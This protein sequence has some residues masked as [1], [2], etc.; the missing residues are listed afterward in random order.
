MAQLTL[1]GILLHRMVLMGV[2]FGDTYLNVGKVSFLT[3]PL[4]LAMD[5]LFLFGTISDVGER[6]LKD[7]F[8]GLYALALDRDASVADYRVQG[9]DNSICTP[10]F[11]RD[12]FADDDILLRFFSK[13]REAIPADSTTDKVRWKQNTKGCFT[14]RSFYLKLLNF[15]YSVLEI[16]G[17]RGFP[18]QHIWRPLTPVKVSF[19]VWEASHGKILT[20]DNLYKK[21]TTLVNKCSCV[22]GTLN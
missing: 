8:P 4:R 7:L 17:D 6:L 3:F 19:F 16:L 5:L 21:G 15:N 20:I 18:C 22:K 11:V 10:I 14:V 1:V 13:L 9:P 12:R 2:V